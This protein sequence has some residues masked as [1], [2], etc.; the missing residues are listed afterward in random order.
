MQPRIFLYGKATSFANY[1]MAIKASGGLAVFSK[2]LADADGCDGLLLPG[3]SDLEP[4]LYGQ[5]NT[6]SQN[7]DPVRDAAEL[8]LLNCFVAKGKPVFGICRGLQ[9]INVA[10]G[11]TLLQDVGG[12]NAD[13]LGDRFHNTYATAGTFPALLYSSTF[14]VNSAHH[15]AAGQPGQGLCI[16]QRSEDGIAEALCHETLPVF[17]VQWHPERLCGHFARNDVIDGSIIFDYFLSKCVAN[18]Q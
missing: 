6:A 11:G 3:G 18:T 2:S 16:V 15:Q 17:A 10:F 13:K 5:V 9:V 1:Q 8:W 7:I 4:N 14:F 12:H